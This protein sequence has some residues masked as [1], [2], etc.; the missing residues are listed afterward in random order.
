MINESGALRP[1]F[2]VRRMVLCPLIKV[3][4]SRPF[5]H[6]ANKTPKYWIINSCPNRTTKHFVACCMINVEGVAPFA[7]KSKLLH[8]H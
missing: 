5:N 1:V 4:I 8:G 2:R 7:L 3:I 6:V